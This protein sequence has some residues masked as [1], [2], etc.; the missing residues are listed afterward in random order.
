MTDQ[1]IISLS[2]DEFQLL[3]DVFAGVEDP[4]EYKSELDY[5]IDNALDVV[6]DIQVES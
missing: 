1:F 5:I 2:A 4:K 6:G 3:Q